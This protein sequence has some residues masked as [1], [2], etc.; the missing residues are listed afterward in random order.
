MSGSFNFAVQRRDQG[1]VWLAPMIRARNQ[2]ALVDSDWWIGSGD[3]GTEVVSADL[4]Y[5][6]YAIVTH[7]YID[8]EL[9]DAVIV[10][11]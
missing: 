9:Q 4:P 10:G 6:F 1:R 8:F 2:K 11:Q 3:G 7:L 5:V